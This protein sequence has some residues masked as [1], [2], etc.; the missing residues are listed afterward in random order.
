MKKALILVLMMVASMFA[1][2]QDSLDTTSETEISVSLID[3]ILIQAESY[4]GVPY[5]Y[6]GTGES[7][8]DCSG[9]VY[10]VFNDNGVALPRTVTAIEE[11]GIPVSIDSLLPG[12]L[13]IF[14]N[15]THTG[16]YIGSGEFI[17]SSSY[18]NR[19]VVI[20]ELTETNYA[21]RYHSA[22]RIVTE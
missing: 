20:T 12:D 14:H 13:L 11:I 7:G 4:L 22:V 2:I 19:G 10:R 18:Q 21:R 8:F 3:S 16:I 6:G 5:V 1:Q 15:P 9:L 17:H